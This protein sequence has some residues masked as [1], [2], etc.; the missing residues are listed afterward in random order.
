MK[1]KIMILILLLVNMSLFST[2]LKVKYFQKDRRYQYRIALLKL[3]LDNAMVKNETYILEPFAGDITQ[4]RGL[5]YLEEGKRVNIAFLPL[6]KEREK[7]FLSIKIPILRGLLGY[8]VLLVKDDGLVRFSQ[9]NSLEELKSNYKAGFG[10]QWA[11]MKILKI[12]KI[13]V[14]GSVKYENLFKMLNAHRFD[15]FP[16]GIN[17]AWKEKETHLG[18]DV[19]PYIALYYPYPVYFF[20]NKKDTNLALKIEKGLNIAYKNGTFKKLFL[21]YHKKTIEKANLKN[22]KLFKLKNPTLPSNTPKIDT[23]WWLKQKK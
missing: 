21:K 12:N 8:R 10:S 11:D 22:R 20:V 2:I 17:E 3:A 19:D 23:S 6:N 5:A 7:R 4:E 9:I 15:Y 14:I 13:P 1:A 16:R 18:L